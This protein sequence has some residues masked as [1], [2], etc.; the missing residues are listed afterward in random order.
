MSRLGINVDR[1]VEDDRSLAYTAEVAQ[2]PASSPAR[3]HKV[4][5]GALQ[6]L[7]SK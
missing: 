2:F 6:E 5:D 7:A 1:A 3:L 4:F